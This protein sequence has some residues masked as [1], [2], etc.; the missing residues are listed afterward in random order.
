MLYKKRATAKPPARA[1][2]PAFACAAPLAGGVLEDAAA[3]ALSEG[4]WLSEVEGSAPVVLGAAAE[5]SALMVGSVLVVVMVIRVVIV[6]GADDELAV[7][8][9]GTLATEDEGT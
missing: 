1:N 3:G 7:V 6:E 2:A 9:G 4:V 5:D 8:V